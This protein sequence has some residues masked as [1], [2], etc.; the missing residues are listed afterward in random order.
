MENGII[1][2][3]NGAVGLGLI[4]FRRE[5]ARWVLRSQNRFWGFRFGD[6][7]LRVTELVTGIVGLGFLVVGAFK[8]LRVIMFN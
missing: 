1:D 7:E 5:F 8:L 6:A 2:S 3:L 4:L